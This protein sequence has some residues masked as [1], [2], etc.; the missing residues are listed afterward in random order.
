L[1][2]KEVSVVVNV[3]VVQSNSDWAVSCFSCSWQQRLCK[4]S[5]GRVTCVQPTCNETWTFILFWRKKPFTT[6]GGLTVRI[7]FG[8]VPV[9]L[10]FSRAVSL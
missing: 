9:L 7:S 10:R 2:D 8:C 1:W 6:Y 5:A 3:A 4:K